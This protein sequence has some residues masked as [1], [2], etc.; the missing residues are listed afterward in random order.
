MNPQFNFYG[1]PDMTMIPNTGSY[2]VIQVQLGLIYLVAK[3]VNYVATRW[4]S[5][6]GMRILGMSVYDSSTLTSL[7]SGS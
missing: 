4:A 5:K 3:L 7:F 6:R 1:S 2:F